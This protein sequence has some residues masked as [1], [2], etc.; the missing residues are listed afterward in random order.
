MNPEL[1]CRPKD[2]GDPRPM[3]YLLKKILQ[4]GSEKKPRK[5]KDLQSTQLNEF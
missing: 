5:G 4:T 3:V 1:Y 2:D